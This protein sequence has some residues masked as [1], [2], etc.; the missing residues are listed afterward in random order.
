MSPD[1][2][3]IARA[4]EQLASDPESR[5]LAAAAGVALRRRFEPAVVA[6]RFEALYAEVAAQRSRGERA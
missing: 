3:E 4:I 6:E 1:A 2:R 5:R